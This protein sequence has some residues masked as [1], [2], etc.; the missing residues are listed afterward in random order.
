[1]QSPNIPTKFQNSLYGLCLLLDKEVGLDN[2]ATALYWHLT[3]VLDPHTKGNF[4][5]FSP[6]FPRKFQDKF[7]MWSGVLNYEINI[8]KKSL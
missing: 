5:P 4:A 7:Y 8:N 1:M 6:S 3:S 2:G